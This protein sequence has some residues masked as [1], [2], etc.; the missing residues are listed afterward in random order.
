MLDDGEE[1]ED[2]MDDEQVKAAAARARRPSHSRSRSTSWEQ[3][4]AAE[5]GEL[6]QASSESWIEN[7]LSMYGE[8]RGGGPRSVVTLDST[9]KRFGGPLGE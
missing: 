2:D 8:V 1:T 4:W 5:I 3:E 6:A 7:L 9:T